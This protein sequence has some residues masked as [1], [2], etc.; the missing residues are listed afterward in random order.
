MSRVHL[1]MAYN[2][3]I[4]LGGKGHLT[5]YIGKAEQALPALSRRSGRGP[6]GS[7]DS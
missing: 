4:G 2:L 6:R 5:S 1:V 3:I 7:R